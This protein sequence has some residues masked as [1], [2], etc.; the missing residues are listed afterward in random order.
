MHQ[1]TGSSSVAV[2]K[3]EIH[4]VLALMRANARYSAVWR[5]TRESPDNKENPLVAGLKSLHESLVNVRDLSDADT[6]DWLKPFLDIIVTPETSGPITG[7]ALGSISKF[8]LYEFVRSEKK[9]GGVRADEGANRIAFIVC[10]CRFEATD[11][12][13]DEVVSMKIVQVLVDLMRCS[14]G[15]LLTDHSVYEICLACLGICSQSRLSE[16]LRRAAEH[17]LT[18]VILTVFSRLSCDA[19]AEAASEYAPPAPDSREKSH[20]AAVWDER[21]ESASAFMSEADE[22]ECQDA[23]DKREI[24]PKSIVFKPP[25][26]V[27]C[28]QKI[29]VLLCQLTDPSK[30]DER[31]RVLGLSLLNVVLETCGS[32]LS[33]HPSL[34]NV[35]QNTLC[36]FLLQNSRTTSLSILSLVLR[37][38]FNMFNSVGVHLKVQLEVFFNSM[39]LALAESLSSPP[40]IREMA[41]ESLI[42][43]CR[44]PQLIID[45]YV[46]YDCA[47]QSTNLF[48]RLVKFL[49]KMSEPGT[50]MN[51][52]N[53]QA[54]E[55]ILAILGALCKEIDRQ[56]TQ[57]ALSDD[58]DVPSGDQQSSATDAIRHSRIRK[59][60]LQVAAEAFNKNPKE[61]VR[62][63][64]SYGFAQAQEATPDEVAAFLKQ[65][66]GLNKTVV[67]EYLGDHNAF[68]VAVLTAYAKTFSFHNMSLDA[69]LRLFLSGFRLC[70]EAQKIDRVMEA[71]SKTMHEHSPGPLKKWDGAFTLAFSLIML[72]TDIHSPN[73]KNKMTK[74]QFIKNNKGMNAGEDFP[75]E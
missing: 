11:T 19:V 57:C 64:Q 41:L 7:G 50:S 15:A 21:P 71:F 43:F 1:V 60:S 46:N 55:G 63:L 26:G 33:N 9:G 42:E 14:A 62:N 75:K 23:L 31:S 70:G 52:F 45:L 59:K 68:N 58:A 74:E 18:Q 16:L 67:G 8:L 38:V 36:K 10:R 25:H 47:V 61:S 65:A 32:S 17:C 6:V 37:A 27:S 29:L 40:L 49:F 20:V 4:N 2:L 51:S 72:N 73:V 48:E 56:H 54:F 69:A 13:S 34:V 12:D 35:M 5:F 30:K 22:V 39:H 53:L 66:P 3:G 44:E 28:M 24:W